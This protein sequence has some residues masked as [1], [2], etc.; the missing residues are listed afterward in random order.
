M[1]N[2]KLVVDYIQGGKELYSR[3]FPMRK[4][5]LAFH[6]NLPHGFQQDFRT[7]LKEMNENWQE[8]EG[9]EPVIF[10]AV[11]NGQD[12][13]YILGVVQSECGFVHSIYIEPETRRSGI[14]YE[15]MDRLL[16]WFGK[17][18]L[19]QVELDVCQG[20]ED[21]FEFYGHFGFLPRKTRLIKKIK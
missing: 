21:V 2:Q 1:D 11:Q 9:R 19:T 17:Q 13:G 20:N 18:G 15:L 7:K 5:L 14:G 4:K 6:A 8:N 3:V 12:C 10:L 16:T